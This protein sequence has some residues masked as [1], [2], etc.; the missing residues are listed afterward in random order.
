M[1]AAV[2]RQGEL[3]VETV[4]DP[5]PATGQVLVAS[6]ANGICGS[7][8]HMLDGMKLAAA[9]GLATAP[10]MILGH[11]FCGEVLDYGPST[12]RTVPIGR[13]VCANPFL[14]DGSE[15]VGY[16]PR[17]PGGL[18]ELMVLD[19]DRLLAAPPGV[20][21]EHLA[22]TEPLAVGIRAV[23]AAAAYRSAGPYVVIGCGPIG[24]SVILALR[25]AGRGPI[26]A[27]DLA[28]PRLKLAEQLGADVVVDARGGSAFDRLGD[29]GLVESLPSP[30]LAGRPARRPGPIV[31]ECVGMPGMIQQ[32]LDRAPRHSQVIVVGVCTQPDT[33]QPAVATSKEISLEFVLAYRPGEFKT[34]FRRIVGGIVDASPMITATVGLDEASWAVE[35]LR[36]TQH[37]KIIVRPNPVAAPRRKD[38][39]V[40]T[41]V[42]PIPLDAPEGAAMVADVVDIDLL[43]ASTFR[44]G[45]PYHAFEALRRHAPVAWHAEGPPPPR[46]VEPSPLGGELLESPGFW[47]VTSHALVGDVSRRPEAFSSWIGG[48]SIRSSDE[49]G[50]ASTRQM[51][52]NMDPPDH[53]RLRRI[54]QPIF[55]PKAVKRLHESIIS[56]SSQI[57]DDVAREGE[58]D[59]VLSVASELPI[60]VLVDLLGMPYEDRRL[61]FDWSNTLIGVEDPEYGGDH[62]KVVTAMTAMFAYGKAIADSRR[63]EPRD[64]I[65]SMIANAEVDGERLTDLEFSLFWLL[66]V[67]AGNETTRNTLSGGIMALHEHGLWRQLRDDRALLPTAVDEIVRYVS[68][69][70][71]F[72]RTAVQDTTLGDQHIRA[73]D[74]VVVYYPAAQ[75]S[76]SPTIWTCPG[77][78]TLIW[79][80]ASVPTSASAPTW[81]SSSSRRSSTSSSTGS[82]TS[83]SRGRSRGCAPTSSPASATFR[84]PSHPPPRRPPPRPRRRQ[85]GG[86]PAARKRPPGSG[87]AVPG[88]RLRFIAVLQTP[89]LAAMP[90]S[91]GHG[92]PGSLVTSPGSCTSRC[93][94]ARR[95]RPNQRPGCG[96]SPRPARRCRTC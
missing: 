37:A 73:G 53:S 47:V 39:A 93:G 68:P 94:R 29:L 28:E 71:H 31:F 82:P 20:P 30:V 85:G 48:T 59:F 52:L 45:I 50:L 3:A 63:A 49:A 8:L 23:N 46:M 13:L 7:D 64:D 76:T 78:R 84:S 91:P 33:L 10:P 81:P 77:H 26:V 9:A 36:Q 40:T 22:L 25:A 19:A 86:P 41:I 57:V 95:G 74:K 51:M 62:T 66:L 83:T 96:R 69:V 72:R 92:R 58:C 5:V 56:H 67:V 79:P 43:S 2:A 75:C 70:I 65:V 38:H 18:A 34:A 17:Y 61:L 88:G 55:T 14:G 27:A 6:R 4:D 24:L 54:L 11:E 16:S 12:R 89:R 15:L 60:R 1:R 90:G 80:S 32:I 44:D 42:P 35:A 21:A 87:L